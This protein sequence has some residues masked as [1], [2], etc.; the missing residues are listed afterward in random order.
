MATKQH[1]SL[2]EAAQ[3]IGVSHPTLRRWIDLNEGPLAIVKAAGT[4]KTYRI[5]R[6]D[7]DR[8]VRRNSKG[9]A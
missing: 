5:K 6:E 7:F 3:L 9:V 1:I 8:W 4:R 2:R